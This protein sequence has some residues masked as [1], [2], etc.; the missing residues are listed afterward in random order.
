MPPTLTVPRELP[1]KP[2][3]NGAVYLKLLVFG[4]TG[5]GKTRFCLTFCQD[6]RTSPVLYVDHSRGTTGILAEA[7]AAGAT[8]RSAG[9]M[10]DV[11]SILSWLK[12]E[13]G[14]G[15]KTVIFDDF[16]EAFGLTKA[17]V[18]KEKI[19][20]ADSEK[21]DWQGYATLYE[22]T[23]N[24]LREATL[25]AATPVEAGG[26]GVHVVMTCWAE[27]ERDRDDNEYWV[28]QF[29]GKYGLERVVQYFDVA[30]FLAHDVKA[31][32]EG[33]TQRREFTNRLITMSGKHLVKDRFDSTENGVLEL[34]TATKLLDG[35]AAKS[36]RIA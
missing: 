10:G 20:V 5:A 30:G 33:G 27:K 29:S 19:G 1:G 28:P 35:I 16:S 18:A 8:V 23:T 26:A 11:R 22:R 12:A 9:D 25:T 13:K 7:E 32:R 4:P 6:P 3:V 15:Y 17:T 31:V 24:R 36:H 2:V 21:L 34:P 14:G